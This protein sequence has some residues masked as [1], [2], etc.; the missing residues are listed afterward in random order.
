MWKGVGGCWVF[1]LYE[2]ER[3]VGIRLVL[4]GWW[5]LCDQ[6]LKPPL[7]SCE[8][9]AGSGLSFSKWFHP[10]PRYIHPSSPSFAPLTCFC[11]FSVSHIPLLLLFFVFFSSFCLLCLQLPSPTAMSTALR[12][13]SCYLREVT[14]WLFCS[15]QYDPPSVCLCVLIVH[16]STWLSFVPLDWYET[17]CLTPK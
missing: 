2:L 10:L 3:A 13:I 11:S 7:S 5:P 6:T 4:W 15:G 12:G 8:P 16:L 14:T 1:V 9:D 17:L